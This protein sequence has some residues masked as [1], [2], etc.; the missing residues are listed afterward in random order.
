[1]FNAELQKLT[2]AVT[3]Q[4]LSMPVTL[5]RARLQ[6]LR[7]E[8]A[9]LNAAIVFP[10][11]PSLRYFNFEKGHGKNKEAAA[12]VVGR[13]TAIRAISD[14]AAAY[15]AAVQARADE[16]AARVHRATTALEVE[17]KRRKTTTLC[18]GHRMRHVT[19]LPK[20]PCEMYVT[21]GD[22]ATQDASRKEGDRVRPCQ[23]RRRGASGD[24]SRT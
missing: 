19:T 20:A 15:A 4:D 7:E 23:R 16:E 12:A 10:L 3:L 18:R 17:R 5:V 13:I 24:G 2:D 9:L 6:I 11:L 1:L 14:D 8:P 22:V 21:Q